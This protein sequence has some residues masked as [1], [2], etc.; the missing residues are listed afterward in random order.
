MTDWLSFPI[1]VACQG[2]PNFFLFARHLQASAP[3][4]SRKTPHRQRETL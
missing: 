2:E 3:F 4:M 1:K